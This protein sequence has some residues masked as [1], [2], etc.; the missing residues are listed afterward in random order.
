MTVGVTCQLRFSISL[1][2]F[3]ASL[4]LVL[5][6]VA[7]AEAAPSLSLGSNANYQLTASVSTSQSCSTSPS[8]YN[9]IACLGQLPPALG[10][11]PV[12]ITA[13][14]FTPGT[15]FPAQFTNV[16]WTNNDGIPHTVTSNYTS[17]ASFYFML[18]PG[19]SYSLTFTRS[20]TYQYYDAARTSIKGT[21]V[22]TP[23]LPPLAPA[24][25]PMTQSVALS[26]PVGW[27]VLGVD[28]NVVVLNVTHTL[29]LSASMAGYTLTTPISESGSFERSV[30]MATRVQS[31][32]ATLDLAT[33]LLQA[34]ALA[35]AGAAVP[36]PVGVLPLAAPLLQSMQTKPVYT[37]W[38]VNGPL[39]SGQPVLVLTGY[40]SVR[41]SE[42]VN[43]GGSLGSRTAWIVGSQLTQSLTAVVPTGPSPASANATSKLS[44]QFDYDQSSDI[45]LKSIGL[46]T[47]SVS[48]GTPTN[49]GSCL[50]A[51]GRC[52][53]A[54]VAV[55][56]TRQVLITVSLSM[57]LSSTNVPSSSRS[58]AA[59]GSSPLSSPWASF[60]IGIGVAAAAA[61][62]VIGTRALI[63]RRGVKPATSAE[64]S[65]AT[66]PTPPSSPLPTP[67][68]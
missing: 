16:T 22:V 25:P 24:S 12:S 17:P 64:A 68:P 3:L 51:S 5:L 14:G 29:S 31:P 46:I 32:G 49:P 39:A 28:G 38:W 47:F 60:G 15:V 61:V 45:L 7:P 4:G 56:V 26:G 21:V 62:A 50:Y 8:N 54:P 19:Q 65:P 27:N 9:L 43:I 10:S 37:I 55:M 18:N 33:I 52:V 2:P 1:V 11:T 48:T 34:A 20:G 6:L 63:A 23:A 40:G 67:P 57:Q 58:F 13:G 53:D 30:T 44:L 35:L 42:T 66:P 59:E 41:G 36:G